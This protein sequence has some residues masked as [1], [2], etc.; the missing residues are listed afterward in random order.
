LL[1][2]SPSKILSIFLNPFL[3]NMIFCGCQLFL[4]INF[5]QLM[6]QLINPQFI[7]DPNLP[8]PF[9]IGNLELIFLPIKMQPLILPLLVELDFTGKHHIPLT[10]VLLEEVF[11]VVSE[12]VVVAFHLA[13]DVV[14]LVVLLA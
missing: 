11:F 3:K 10:P 14:E 2:F 7:L 8:L 9:L 4:L 6:G 13:D 5:S 12:S 1:V